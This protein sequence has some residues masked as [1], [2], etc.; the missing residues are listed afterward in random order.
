MSPVAHL[1][2]LGTRISSV[3]YEEAVSVILDKAE[4]D[5]A[6]HA[7]VCAANVHTVSMARQNPAYRKVL[8]GSLLSVPDGK[9]LIWAHRILGGRKLADR[10]YGPTLMLRLCHAAAERSLPIYLYGGA[11]GVAEKL[12]D[13]LTQRFP[14]LRVAGAVSPP[15]GERAFDDPT[16]VAEIDVINR[17]GARILFVALG[18]PKQEIFMHAN[19]AR[20]DPIQIGVG[21]AFD[22]HTQRVKQA[23]DWMQDSGLEWLFRF[24][25]EPQ[26]LWR[27]YL[28]YN[29]YFVARLTLQ[30][31]GLDG[32]SREVLKM[33]QAEVAHETLQR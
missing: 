30:R 8:N 2:I 10:V 9:P 11:A 12:G 14:K 23:P 24:C 16:L 3:T 13:A 7:Y 29:P 18:A 26:R 22:F 27:R 6:A 32:P 15:Y 21:A 17:S 1:P 19:T 20:I 5:D 33:D 4:H 25:M 28:F 31:L